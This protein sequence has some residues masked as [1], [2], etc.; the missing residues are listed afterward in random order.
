MTAVRDLYS[1]KSW[2]AERGGRVG[3]TC[4]PFPNVSDQEIMWHVSL[5][6]TVSKRHRNVTSK[7]KVA[8]ERKVPAKQGYSRESH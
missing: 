3:K 1:G 4:P 7:M 8:T 6:L 2:W 5:R